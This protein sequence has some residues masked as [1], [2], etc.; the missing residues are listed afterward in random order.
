MARRLGKEGGGR[1]GASGAV[2]AAAEEAVVGSTGSEPLMEAL[3]V[4]VDSTRQCRP[5][6]LGH[7]RNPK[8]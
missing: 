6:E 7:S 1:V 8:P 5:S 4:A 2:Q 3:V